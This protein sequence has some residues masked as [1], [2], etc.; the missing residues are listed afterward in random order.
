MPHSKCKGSVDLYDEYASVRG[1]DIAIAKDKLHQ[2]K[3]PA[4]TQPCEVMGIHPN[5]PFLKQ[6]YDEGDALMLANM[7]ALVE[8]SSRLKMFWCVLEREQEKRRYHG[9][10]ALIGRLYIHRKFVYMC[11]YA[12]AV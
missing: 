9:F 4:G 3:V 6:L 5:M 8:V 10:R 7:G 2:I 1:P 11:I 12:W